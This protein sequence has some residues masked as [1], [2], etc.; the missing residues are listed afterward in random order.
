MTDDEK[1]LPEPEDG[2][3]EE[4]ATGEEPVEAPP[5]EG[6]PAVVDEGLRPEEERK[7]DAAPENR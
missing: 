7:L 2:E 6:E 1:I 4:D 3:E 5:A